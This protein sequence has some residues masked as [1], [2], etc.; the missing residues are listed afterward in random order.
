MF[1]SALLIFYIQS[2]ISVMGGRRP[3]PQ[4]DKTKRTNSKTSTQS[5]EN[6]SQEPLG[7]KVASTRRVTRS[8]T[9]VSHFISYLIIISFLQLDLFFIFPLVDNFYR[10]IRRRP[11]KRNQICKTLIHLF[12]SL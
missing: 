4:K 8:S 9:Q 10:H 6:D 1:L 5:Q 3:A 7:E 2:A 11:E 12:L